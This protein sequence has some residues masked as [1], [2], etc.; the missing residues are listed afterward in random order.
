MS[1]GTLG[2]REGGQSGTLSDDGSRAFWTS[3]PG[4]DL[5][6]REGIATA[7]PT[8]VQVDAGVGGRGIFLTASSDGTKVFF[9][10]AI[11]QM[12]GTGDAYEYDMEKP[13]GEA[14]TDLIPEERGGEAEVQGVLGAS[15]DGSYLYFVASGALAR[16]AETEHCEDTNSAT[17]CNLYLWHAGAGITFVARLTGGDD[18]YSEGFPGA[19]QGAGDWAPRFWDHTARVSADGRHVVFMSE[20]PL[21][22][23][24]NAG[25]QEVYQMKPGLLGRC[26]CRVT[27]PGRDRWV[28]RAFP[29]RSS[30]D[31]V[32]R[33]TPRGS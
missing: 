6:A 21:T 3:I 25:V 33:S 31:L 4:E 32:R 9:T 14:L 16:G 10:T 5:Y 18:L 17:G 28:R 19:T 23:Y 27:R 12:G 29:L 2:S 11:G 13:E 20:A 8:T 30:L 24:D 1:H 26:A 15:A 7:H 22:A